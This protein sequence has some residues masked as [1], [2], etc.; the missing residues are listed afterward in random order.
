MRNDGDFLVKKHLKLLQKCLA[1]LPS[2]YAGLEN[3]RLTLLFFIIGSL[4]L[5]GRLESLISEDERRKIIEWIYSL[6]LTRSSKCPA[7]ACGF[8]G[9]TLVA[10][11]DE[12][13]NT[14]ASSLV[15]LRSYYESAHVAQT[16]SAL[17][18][19]LIL[20]DDLTR[21]DKPAVLSAVRACQMDDGSFCAFGHQTENDMRFVF[22]AVSISYILGDFSY[23]DVDKVCDFIRRSIS[24]DGGI[25]QGPGLESHGGSTYCA[26]ASLSLMGRLWDGSVL[27]K[28]QIE[29][30]KK[31]AMFKQDQGFHG[32]TNKP[33]DSC[34]AFWIGGTLKMLNSD[35][36][37]DHTALRAF[38]ISTQDDLIGGF[39][40]YSDSTSDVLHTYFSIAALSIFNE[41]T[42]APTYVP[43]NVPYRAFDHLQRLR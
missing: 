8:R 38:L 15:T 22:C 14:V 27:T 41:P 2:A 30:L 9:S 17:C 7:E 13:G 37:V 23:I 5:L 25:G 43:L 10:P 1:S 40:K 35:S 28:Q 31:W 21:V 6:Q 29:R 32:R 11:V 12:E 24:Y 36:L 26:I 3:N 20:R 39:S 18:C 4:D 19:L 42:L 34:Y 16:Y 33:D